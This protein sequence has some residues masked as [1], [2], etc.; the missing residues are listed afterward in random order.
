MLVGASVVEQKKHETMCFIL[1]VNRTN[2]KSKMDAK[3]LKFK[4]RKIFKEKTTFRLARRA[5][6]HMYHVIFCQN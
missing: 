5:Q 6:E 2:I 1:S 4:I 3:T